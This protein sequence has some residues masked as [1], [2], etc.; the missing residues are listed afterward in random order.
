MVPIRAG[1]LEALNHVRRHFGFSVAST[2]A[3]GDSGND[4]LMLSGEG[5]GEGRGGEGRGGEGR[6]GEVGGGGGGGGGGGEEWGGVGRS[7]EG[8]KEEKEGGCSWFRVQAACFSVHVPHTYTH[9][10][11]PAS[12]RASYPKPCTTPPCCLA[13]PW[14]QLLSS[15]C[16]TPSPPSPHRKQRACYATVPGYAFTVY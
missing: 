6:G 11:T 14:A 2:V 15:S 16:P 3:C 1:K 5:R 9:T 7:R 13:D 10:H 4:I 8:G 12:A